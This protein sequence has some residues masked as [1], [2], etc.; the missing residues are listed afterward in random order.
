MQQ[1]F[2]PE[3]LIAYLYKET[4]VS[5]S[6]E[7]QDAMLNDCVL[8]QQYDELKFVQMR[9]P[10]VTFKAAPAAL[11]NILKYSEASTVAI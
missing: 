1:N 2:T 8:Q 9:L 7:I 11:Q 10:N 3:H 6:N 4:S 5:E